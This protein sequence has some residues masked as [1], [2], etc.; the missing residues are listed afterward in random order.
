MLES[1]RT[2][3][4]GVDARILSERVTGIGRYTHEMLTQLV[5]RG[6]EWFLYSH[7]PIIV[8]D[9][10]R[11]NVRIRVAN[12]LEAVNFPKRVLRLAWAQTV[13]PWWASQD[14]VD[15]FWSPGHRLPRYLS[16]RIARVVTIHDLVWKHAGETMRPL[17]V[18]W[19]PSKC[20]RRCALPTT[21]LRCPVIPHRIWLRKCRRLR[22]RLGW[23][24][25]GALLYIRPLPRNH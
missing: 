8:G 9:W 14:K 13:L 19:T 21:L 6:H 20:R 1:G 22:V 3:R 24:I 23:Y 5:D 17:L 12:L 15:L 7:R 11:Y 2:Y 18:G 4:I 25:W 10:S 16:K